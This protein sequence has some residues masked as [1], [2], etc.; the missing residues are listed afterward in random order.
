MVETLTFHILLARLARFGLASRFGM[1]VRVDWAWHTTAMLWW[2][3]SGQEL[4]WDCFVPASSLS[5][6]GLVCWH[7]A[8][9]TYLQIDLPRPPVSFE[10]LHIQDHFIILVLSG[11]F[12]WK[13]ESN[14]FCCMEGT[15]QFELWVNRLD[16]ACCLSVW[17]ICL[18]LPQIFSSESLNFFLFWSGWWWNEL[19]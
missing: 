3:S 16:S 10:F 4:S 11:F 19:E 18:L 5:F 6:C 9:Q 7:N 15:F 1:W 2:H 13:L 14:R 17:Y 12:I 8:Y